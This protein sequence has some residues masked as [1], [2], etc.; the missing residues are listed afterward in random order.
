MI[1]R[2]E[3]QLSQ[4]DSLGRDMKKIKENV[5]AIQVGCKNCG[6]AHL[7]KEC[8]LHEEVKNVE[9]VKYGE[10]GLFSNKEIQEEAEEVEDI[11]E[12]AAHHEPVH[13]KVT[14]NN[15]PIVSY[16]VAPYEPSIL[17]PKRLE[18][19]VEEALVH[20]AMESLKRIKVNCP[21]L[22]EIRQIDD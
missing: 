12:V 13:Q 17:F 14:P 3:L 6:G 5:H 11:E 20:K 1:A 10:F 9:K 8:L 15:L 21:L 7:N 19:H 2:M 22:K 18:Q 4:V 16:Y